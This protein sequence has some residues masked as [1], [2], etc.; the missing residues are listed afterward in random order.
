MAEVCFSLDG[1]RLNKSFFA[2]QI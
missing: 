2:S 1:F